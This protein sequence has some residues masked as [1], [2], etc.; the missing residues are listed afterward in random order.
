MSESSENLA[1]ASTGNRGE[2]A[3]NGKQ[4]D[5]AQKQGGEQQQDK[6]DNDDSRINNAVSL[7]Q[8]RYR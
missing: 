2:H 3:V 7:L 1:S 4:Q 5:S 6:S 8:D